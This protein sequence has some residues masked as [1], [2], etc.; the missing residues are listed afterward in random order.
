MNGGTPEEFWF[1]LVHKTVEPREGC[2]NADRLGPYPDQIAASR[3]L[4]TVEDRNK[5]WDEDPDW[6]DDLDEQ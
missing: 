3:A 2:K 5:A 1:C 6:N 4:Q